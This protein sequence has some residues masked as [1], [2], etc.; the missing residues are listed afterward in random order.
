MDK[1]T[2]VR[3]VGIKTLQEKTL[4][5]HVTRGSTTTELNGRP[6]VLVKLVKKGTG[7]TGTT[8]SA[9]RAGIKTKEGKKCARNAKTAS[10]R[11]SKPRQAAKN[12]KGEDTST[13][14]G[15]IPQKDVRIAPR[16]ESM[17]QKGPQLAR[18]AP[19]ARTCPGTPPP[20]KDTNARYA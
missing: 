10:T 2:I 18:P 13:R 5:R 6:K 19:K 15:A 20:I 11:I 9:N 16:P 7:A 3:Q 8:I 14:R 1:N 12:V 4:A 17:Q